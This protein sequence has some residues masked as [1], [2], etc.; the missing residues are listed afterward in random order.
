MRAVHGCR[1]PV[2]AAISLV[3]ALEYGDALIFRELVEYYE[4]LAGVS[5]R[6]KMIDILTELFGKTT[7]SEIAHVDIH[8]AGRAGYAFRGHR[9][10]SCGED[11]AGCHCGRD[12]LHKGAGRRGI[13]EE[14]RPGHRHADAQ[15]E[16][17]AQGDGPREA[18]RCGHLCHDA[19]DSRDRRRGSKDLKIRLLASM[20]AAATPIEAKYIVRYPLGELRLGVGD[21]TI[22]EALS[23][24]ATG[25]REFKSRA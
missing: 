6:L 18:E 4:R 5:S 15:A 14:W 20:V 19:Q 9:V 11:G 22:L 17:Q 25:S 16:E 24:T 23:A 12:G 13:Q 2:T 3:L 1:A 21:A 8:N 7:D 10:R